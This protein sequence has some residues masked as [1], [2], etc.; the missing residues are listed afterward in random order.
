MSQKQ[1][2]FHC[3][4]P[5]AARRRVLNT[6]VT[7]GGFIEISRELHGSERIGRDRVI[8]RQSRLAH[9]FVKGLE[10]GRFFAGCK[11]IHRG[12]A[13]HNRFTRFGRKR[14]KDGG[15]KNDSRLAPGSEK[16]FPETC[17]ILAGVLILA[18]TRTI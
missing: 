4:A 15:G 8:L 13:K 16:A 9:Q 12:I 10:T 14:Q 17:D 7:K 18:Q 1:L 2:R 11:F 6:L 5:Q 3:R